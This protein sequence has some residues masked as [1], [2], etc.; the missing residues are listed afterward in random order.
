MLKIVEKQKK[1]WY[2]YGKFNKEKRQYVYEE[3]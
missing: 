2:I 3:K 1:L